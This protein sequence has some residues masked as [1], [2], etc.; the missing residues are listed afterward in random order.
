MSDDRAA[1]A[2]DDSQTLDFSASV[3]SLN[4]DAREVTLATEGAETIKPRDPAIR[5]EVPG[6]EILEELGRGGMGVVYKAR[7]VKLNRVV[8]LKMILSG[9]HA[10]QNDLIRFLAEAEAEASLQHPNIVQLLDSGQHE[11]LPYFTL[12]YI[13]GGSLGDKV[14][15]DPIPPRDAA[16]LV[17]QL[18]RGVAH[19][20]LRGIIHRDLKPE[21]ILLTANGQPKITDFGLA[22]RIQ[23]GAGLTQSGAVMGTPGYMAP[24]QARGEKTVGPSVDIYALGAILYRLTTGHPP[25]QGETALE[26]L[27]ML[28][29]SDP[30]PL[31]FHNARIPRDLE[32]ICLKC[33]HKDPARRYT[34]AEGLAD[35]LLNLLDG[36]PIA[37]RPV[38][39]MERCL[40]W[41]RR[42]PTA[43]AL[44][45]TTSLVLI[46]GLVAGIAFTRRIASERDRAEA[47]FVDADKRAKS[48]RIALE[49]SDTQK[50]FADTTLVDM[51]TSFGL[52]AQ[53]QNKPAV[54][55]LWFASAVAHAAQ[56]REREFNSRVR[57]DLARRNSIVPLRAFDHGGA[58][59]REMHLHVDGRYLITKTAKGLFSF[60]D[61]EAEK[62]I[63]FP[64]EGD[65]TAAAWS[66][67]GEWLALGRGKK[68]E[69]WNVADW[70]RLLEIE[71]SEIVSV[72]AFSKDR[73]YLAM[74]TRN[75][76]VWDCRDRK[77]AT[78]ELS[79][80]EQV[81]HLVF[82]NRCD[83]LATTCEDYHA[84]LLPIGKL[85][86]G[87]FVT[88]KP[89][90]HYAHGSNSLRQVSIAPIFSFDDRALLTVSSSAGIAAWDVST[91]LVRW[92]H[93]GSGGIN[94]MQISPDGATVMAGNFTNIQF[95]SY[96]FGQLNR[97]H[98]PHKHY[99]IGIAFAGDDKRMITASFD[100]TVRVSDN[101][102]RPFALEL[103]HQDGIQHLAVARTRNLFATAQFDG[104]VRIWGF[105]G[106]AVPKVPVSSMRSGSDATA[107]SPDGKMCLPVSL[108]GIAR[109]HSLETGEPLGPE[110]P[111][112][113]FI[114][115]GI[116]AA[117][118]NSVI[119]WGSANATSDT[120]APRLT[121]GWI[122][123]RD[124]K[125]GRLRH[126][127]IPT[128]STPIC[129]AVSPSGRDVVA[130]CAGDEV[131]IFDRET[132]DQKKSGR[133]PVARNSWWYILPVT[134]SFHP[135]EDR[136][137]VGGLGKH[138]LHI[139]SARGELLHQLEMTDSTSSAI[140]SPDGSLIVGASR[141]KEVRFWDAD[142]NAKLAP[143]NHTDWVFRTAF[144]NDSRYLITS[145][146][147]GQACIWDWRNNKL[148]AA[149][150][151]PD[152]AYDARFSPDGRWVFTVSRDGYGR[153]WE[154]L[155]GKPVGPLF[156]MTGTLTQ[157]PTLMA[158]FSPDGRRLMFSSIGLY[159]I[160]GLLRP[161]SAHLS[162]ANLDQLGQ[163]HSGQK[164]S[165][166]SNLANLTS[167]EWLE[168]WRSF[169]TAHPAEQPFPPRIQPAERVPKIVPKSSDPPIGV[170]E[171]RAIPA[172]YRE[173]TAKQIAEWIAALDGDQSAD[174]AKMLL[175]VGPPASA[176]MDIAAQKVD[177]R[178]A[179]IYRDL[180]DR[181]DVAQALRTSRINL[182]LDQSPL[183]DAARALAKATGAPVVYS[184]SSP[185]KLTF[186]LRDLTYWQAIEKFCREADVVPS[187][188]PND[189]RLSDRKG[190]E[191]LLFAYSGPLRTRAAFWNVQSSLNLLNKLT[192][193]PEG[194]LLTL[195]PT[196]EPGAAIVGLGHPRVTIAEDDQGRSLVAP[197]EFAM[198]LRQI[199]AVNSEY[200]AN[201]VINILRPDSRG[202]TLKCLEA[203]VP[204]EVEVRRKDR[205]TIDLNA[206]QGKLFA[207][208]GGGRLK[209]SAVRTAGVGFQSIDLRVET[210]GHWN[211]DV[212]RH[213]FELVDEAG[214]RHRC[215]IP[216][217]V[218]TYAGFSPEDLLL[219]AGCPS[220]LPLAGLI[221]H[222]RLRQR[223]TLVG[224]IVQFRAG[225]MPKAN[226]KLVLVESD[227]VRTE[228]KIEFRDLP[229]P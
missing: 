74:A 37:A 183:A 168:L 139:D 57:F 121:A 83:L 84:R 193:G 142:G 58:E 196:L 47:A 50:R 117:D 131:L 43:A 32:T 184:G 166:G 176:A 152:E 105:G 76:R 69:I 71:H 91:G 97:T 126:K 135:T 115:G 190:D 182:K 110:I 208:A 163:L 10:S 81:V 146:R 147:D 7:Q 129:V 132:S 79:H 114:R 109:V 90:I 178:R 16:I 140:F 55:A 15:R 22:K 186:E 154:W 199:E 127:P 153:C 73:R 6:Y 219:F 227:R 17:E 28:I 95:I 134:V 75:A 130:A 191:N 212:R 203:M 59:I 60:W 11:S 41:V 195:F 225:E 133:F 206:A 38:G 145:G 228:L 189:L 220:H 26:T 104:L 210:G 5:A 85:K 165:G 158:Q 70:K 49:E 175:E 23:A 13:E 209:I 177:A 25:F 179:N 149:L 14:S 40:K 102:G 157:T 200:L 61:I 106:A 92:T 54:A 216:S 46:A 223:G 229:L 155:T 88:A 151:H 94:S 51:Q 207:I 119:L 44:L 185:K 173:A 217:L 66:G 160:E 194:L 141:G 2:P 188:F 107:L 181:I 118:G 214:R 138:I 171:L 8:A 148:L 221:W 226:F 128:R 215:L 87:E 172:K 82:N 64:G 99:T 125:T 35:D 197:A 27:A 93:P 211:Y 67:D 164:I 213:G 201:C 123:E 205:I 45:A 56:D 112:P 100:R 218:E 120:H 52:A 108:D 222:Q 198:P 62:A 136:C 111:N 42:R 167:A 86:P 4:A 101:D 12:E 48:E 21:N 137:V 19:A 202:G 192:P 33:L 63:S 98:T 124:W 204:I 150:Q 39:R 156:P 20:H 78:E 68:V 170:V 162:V 96:Q 80:K 31:R 113:G 29:K 180:R 24:E 122:E 161:E 34:S 144:S 143:L 77:F 187:Q 65:V 72:A 159:D 53:E 30:A 169:R 89:L 9:S 1:R 224:G 116:F 3:A 36:K 103:T 18:A 174:A